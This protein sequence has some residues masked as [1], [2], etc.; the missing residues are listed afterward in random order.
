ME[1]RQYVETIARMGARLRHPED[2]DRGARRRAFVVRLLKLQRGAPTPERDLG[3]TALD[4]FRK[5]VMPRHEALMAAVR[6]GI[7]DRRGALPASAKQQICALEA[8]VDVLGLVRAPRDEVTHTRL[9][10]DLLGAARSTPPPVRVACIRALGRLLRSRATAAALV[11]AVEDARAQSEVW[12]SSERR[13]DLVLTSPSAKIFIEAKIDAGEGAGQ[14]DAYANALASSLAAGQRGLLVFLTAR[15]DQAHSTSQPHVHITFQDLLV[16]WLVAASE[17]TAAEG[18]VLMAYL[19]SVAVHVCGVA[20]DG[21]FDA[22]PVHIQRRCLALY[23]KAG[24]A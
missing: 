18:A 5:Q 16:S 19:K 3:S 6:S 12:V 23:E 13:V 17:C 8:A 11:P 15:T 7:Q 4:A 22:W 14:L 10:A 2:V 21:L 9:I 20:G 1:V 24:D